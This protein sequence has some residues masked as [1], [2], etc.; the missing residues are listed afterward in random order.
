MLNVTEYIH[1]TEEDNAQVMRY[2]YH[3]MDSS[4]QLRLRWDNVRH[5]PGLP[6]FPYHLHERAEKRVLSSEPMNLSKVF[7]RITRY[8]ESFKGHTEPDE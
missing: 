1:A 3:W 5:Y 6:G 7:E 8:L 4:N 2:T